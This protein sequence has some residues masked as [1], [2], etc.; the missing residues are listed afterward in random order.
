M[1]AS[2]PVFVNV[3]VPQL[4]MKIAAAQRKTFRDTSVEFI[5]RSFKL[6]ILRRFSPTYQDLRR[7]CL[8]AAGWVA[9]PFVR[10]R[11]RVGICSSQLDGV[12]STPHEQNSTR[13]RR[14]A[15][16]YRVDALLHDHKQSCS[17]PDNAGVHLGRGISKF[18]LGDKTGACVDWRTASVRGAADAAA[19]ITEYCKD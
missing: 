12:T 18:Y 4:A 3:A 7:Q 19:L 11:G 9:S 17:K 5:W 13:S 15:G 2:L 16:C 14:R 10:E 1:V 6:P 8:A